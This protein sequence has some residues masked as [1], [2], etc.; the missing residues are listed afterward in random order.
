MSAAA[1]TTPAPSNDP[2]LA[3]VDPALI[4]LRD[5]ALAQNSRRQYINLLIILQRLTNKPVF[6]LIMDSD[7]TIDAIKTRYKDVNTRK[8]CAVAVKAAVKHVP[9]LNARVPSEQ[10]K[11]WT[12]FFQENKKI[13]SERSMSGEK[14]DQ[15][16]KT[17]VDWPEVIA[18]RDKL[19]PYSKAHL[20]MCLYTMVPPLRQ[21]FGSVRIF[22]RN[23]DVPDD[24]PGNHIIISTRMFVLQIY[25]TRPSMGIYK[26]QW[27]IPLMRIIRETLRRHP[28]TYL[29][30]KAPGVAFRDTK[31]FKELSNKM[32]RKAFDGKCVSINILRHSFISNLDFN[33]LR[34]YQLAE[35]AS[36]MRHSIAQ[37][38]EYRKW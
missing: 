16:L 9:D 31:E 25:K 30:E 14:N 24:Y 17:W 10:M 1:P 20:M 3:F 22:A 32:F 38:N 36:D 37:Q 7:S 12:D 26:K 29:F 35:I 18:A 4:V 28:R 2:R 27:P 34:P 19:E 8:A 15:Q 5:V 23:D 13:S 11:P 6:D 21:D 33:A